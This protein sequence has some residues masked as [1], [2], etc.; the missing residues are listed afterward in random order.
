MA[1]LSDEQITIS[2]SKIPGW[3][4]ENQNRTIK[5]N[6]HFASF[7]E[8]MQFVHQVGEY[9]EAANHHPD[10]DIR[11]RD[12]TL[13]LTTHDSNGLTGKDFALAQK[14]NQACPTKVDMLD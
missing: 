5:R 6:I 11:Y 14:I 7:P 13:R 2:L 4:L 12:V 1:K 9:A 3:T 10:I 8:A